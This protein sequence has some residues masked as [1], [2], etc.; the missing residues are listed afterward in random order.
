MMRLTRGEFVRSLA[1]SASAAVAGIFSVGSQQ[2][3]MADK[4][5]SNADRIRQ[6]FDKLSKDSF[7]VHVD[8]VFKICDQQSPTFIEATLVEVTDGVSSSEV[9]QFSILFHGPA[10]PML[11][12]QTYT[13]EHPQMG[14]FDLFL[15]PIGADQEKVQY[16]AVFNRLRKSSSS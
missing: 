13:I 16:E 1:V 8:S 15:V 6:M 10:E 2:Q 3:A 4:T 14:N 12:Q 11:P 9:E 5:I 7:S